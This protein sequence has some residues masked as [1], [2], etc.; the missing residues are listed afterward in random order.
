[1]IRYLDLQAQYRSIR[2]EIDAAVH[3]VLDSGRFVLGEEVDAFEREYAAF[4]GASHAVAVNSGTSALHLALLAAGVEA[5]DDVIT[6]PFTFVATVAAIRYAGARP[7][8]V[9]VDPQTCTMA[10]DRLERALTSRT[11]AIVP[12]H[13]YGQPADMDPIVEIARR[14]GVAVIEDAAQAHGAEYR[15]RPCGSLGDLAAF[16]FYPGKNLGAAGEGGIV[17]TSDPARAKKVRLLRSW[18]EERRYEH[19][20]EG[21]NYRMDAMQAAIL[22]V[23]LRYLPLWNAGRVLRADR[24]R[25]QLAATPA[26]QLPRVRPNSTHVYHV[27]AARVPTRDRVRAMLESAGIETAIHYPVP[28]H[29]QPA[30]AELGYKPGMFPVSE[31]AA[32]SVLSLPIDP[33]LPLTDIDVVASELRG[34]FVTAD[35]RSE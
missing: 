14:R 27:F 10:P 35:R 24:Y 8:F 20:L 19:L 32:A 2:Q 1:M 33:Q 3:R 15:G 21:F 25:E 4:C 23:K 22:R 9:D 5:G 16:S 26:V 17:V 7:V 12:V 31:A 30:Y 13:L 18:A 29:L 11:K 34:C 28:V 6:V